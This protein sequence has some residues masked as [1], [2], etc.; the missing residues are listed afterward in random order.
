MINKVTSFLR[1][2]TVKNAGYLI[3]GKIVQMIFGLVVS[4]LTAR[5]LGPSNYGL[6][7]YAT[8]YTGF[9]TALCTLGI[10]NVLVKEFIDH[11][12]QEGMVIGTTLGLRAVSSV[13]SSIAI[14]IISCF[15]D[16]GESVTIAVVALASIGI[17]FQI[18]ET[19]NYW[20]QSQL[21]SKVTAMAVLCAYVI[22]S[23]Y[24]V[25]LLLTGK[26][27]LLF[28]LVTSL[29]YLCLGIILFIQYRKRN[30]G[31]LSFSLQYG[32]ELFGRSKHFILSSLMVAIFGQTDKLMLKHM[33]GEAE[34]GYY[35]IAVALCGMWCF[36]LRA[37]IDSVQPSIMQAAKAQNKEQFNKRNIQLYAIVF[38]ISVFVSLCFTVLAEV[39]V[40]ILYGS[41]YL[42]A[43]APLRIVTWYTAF[44]YL[45]SARNA[46]IVSMGR[47]KYLFRIYA[48]SAL[49]NVLL[50]F[51]LIPIMGA[52]GAAIASLVA[53]VF[54]TLVVPFFIRDMRE[55]SMMILD[56]I[57]LKGIV[58]KRVSKE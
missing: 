54:T 31:K 50:N 38:Y 44:S 27:V 29:D 12:G 32:K 40:D 45:G 49:S 5:Y 15:I 56:A 36:V 34:T 35:A 46:W 1:N 13:L 57:M 42:P 55:N 30:G 16:A 52:S 11:P 53:Q 6:I 17:I 9:F 8:A 48:A 14:I 26:G 3:V 37:I 24:K 7:N 4:L 39:A 10:N 20:F 23:A 28:A 43:I 2:K 51:I 47:Q 25:F 19:F 21:Q 33:Y 22:A 41:E 18:V 58:W